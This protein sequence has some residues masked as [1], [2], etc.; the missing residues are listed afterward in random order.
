MP[1]PVSETIDQAAEVIGVNNI[2]TVGELSAL[3]AAQI[4]QNAVGHTN[5]INRLSENF[6]GLANTATG[7]L[8]KS[9]SEIDPMEAVGAVKTLTG[10]DIASKLS[11]IVGVISAIVQAVKAASITPPETSKTG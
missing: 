9:M 4:V 10:D 3:I 11:N 1:E 8:M 6:L 5:R 7:S 2:K